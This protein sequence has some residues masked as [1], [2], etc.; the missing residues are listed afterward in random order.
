MTKKF[1]IHIIAISCFASCKSQNKQE[2]IQFDL[3]TPKIYYSNIGELRGKIEEITE[4]RTSKINGKNEASDSD[5]YVFDYNKNIIYF[6]KKEKLWYTAF[7]DKNWMLDSSIQI[8]DSVIQNKSRLYFFKSPLHET[9]LNY[10][11]DEGVKSEQHNKIDAIARTVGFYINNRLS[12]VD[13]F[14]IQNRIVQKKSLDFKDAFTYYKY[15]DEGDIIAELLK[16]PNEEMITSQIYEYEYDQNRNWIKKINTN[17]P[18]DPNPGWNTFKTVY[19]RK[20]IYDPN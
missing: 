18:N 17:R 10:R 7:S 19:E 5:R 14:D 16:M 3:K 20:I 9:Y 11:I 2:I 4:T 12:S 15:N 1:L 13:S 6:Y 8:L